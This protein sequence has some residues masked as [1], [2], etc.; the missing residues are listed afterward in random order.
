VR[1]GIGSLFIRRGRAVGLIRFFPGTTVTAAG[2]RTAVVRTGTIRRIGIRRR[3]L[4]LFYTFAAGAGLRR[5]RL[6]AGFRPGRFG[7]GRFGPGGFLTGGF[8][9]RPGAGRFGA[10]RFGPGLVSAFRRA[11]GWAGFIGFILVPAFRSA[12]RA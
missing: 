3:V 8:V 2:R 12:G 1:G 7:P 9:L 4:F 11:A 6:R 10:G 5:R